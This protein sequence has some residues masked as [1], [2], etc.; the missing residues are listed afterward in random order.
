M[1]RVGV[2]PHCHIH[3]AVEMHVGGGRNDSKGG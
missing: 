2:T 1:V 3:V